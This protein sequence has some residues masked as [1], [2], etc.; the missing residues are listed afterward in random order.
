VRQ[1][2]SLAA[3]YAN[4]DAPA[5]ESLAAHVANA[6][7]AALSSVEAP[8]RRI[9]IRFTGEQHTITVVISYAVLPSVPAPGSVAEDGLSVD[10]AAHGSRH[11]C[12]IRQ[13]IPA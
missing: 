6:T 3:G 10:W 5:G 4:L 9:E 11:T 2:T 1:L 13:R 12:E 7:E 8:D